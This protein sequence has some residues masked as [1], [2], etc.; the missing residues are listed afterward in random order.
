MSID[1]TLRPGIPSLSVNTSNSAVATSQRTTPPAVA[2]HKSPLGASAR[3]LMSLRGPAESTTG[4]G[5]TATVVGTT[6]ASVAG[7][8]SSPPNGRSSRIV[9]ATSTRTP[10][11]VPNATAKPRR[12]LGRPA[13]S[14]LAASARASSRTAWAPRSSPRSASIRS[15]RVN[16]SPIG[17]LPG[18]LGVEATPAPHRTFPC[19]RLATAQQ[20]PYLRIAIPL[21]L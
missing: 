10:A 19:R 15:D 6:G 13:A 18:E 3:S 4:S 12:Q 17:H 21:D 1:A 16:S 2:A 14:G 20:S 7:G 5:V 8:A 9:A 11:A